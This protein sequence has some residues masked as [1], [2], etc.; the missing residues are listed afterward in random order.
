MG[1]DV[2]PDLSSYNRLEVTSSSTRTRVVGQAQFVADGAYLEG[3]M[4]D[5]ANP[6]RLF[7]QVEECR[8]SPDPLCQRH[9]F[10]AGDLSAF[11]S[12]LKCYIQL[13][14]DS[15]VGYCGQA[16]TGLCQDTDNRSFGI[17]LSK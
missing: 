5:A 7:V 4:P 13:R 1:L 2:S 11:G 17:T 12:H 3:R 14:N 6:E 8:N 16:I 15:G 10:L 9:F